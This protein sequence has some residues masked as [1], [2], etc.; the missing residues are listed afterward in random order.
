MVGRRTKERE[1]WVP[2]PQVV[3]SRILGQVYKSYVASGYPAVMGTGCTIPK[4]D[5]HV[6]MC[7]C[8][9]IVPGKVMR[10]LNMQMR[11]YQTINW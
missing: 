11:G 2:I 5:N 4:L 1:V 8:D 6:R 7:P 3:M 9:C 10:R